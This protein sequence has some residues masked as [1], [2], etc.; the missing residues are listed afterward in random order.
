M[1]SVFLYGARAAEAAAR[2]EPLWQAWM[3]RQ[4]PA[5]DAPSSVA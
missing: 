2:D 3:N 1:V 5:V 4:F